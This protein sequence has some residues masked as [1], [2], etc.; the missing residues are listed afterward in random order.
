LD[1]KDVL[2]SV[3]YQLLKINLQK[4]E[5]PIRL[6]KLIID[7]YEGTNVRILSAESESRPIEI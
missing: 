7:S 5:L 4:L 2:G 1:C 6:K 3:S